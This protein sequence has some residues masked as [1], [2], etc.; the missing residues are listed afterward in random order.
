MA[1]LVSGGGI[2]THGATT[3]QPLRQ[4]ERLAAQHGREAGSYQK[5][6]SSSFKA[7]DGGHVETHAFRNAETGQ[8]IEPKTVINP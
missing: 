8:I 2:V 7:A 3:N 6:S 1:E 5:V 4:A